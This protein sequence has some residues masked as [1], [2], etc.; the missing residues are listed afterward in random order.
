MLADE[1][2]SNLTRLL[3]NV[4]ETEA[5]LHRAILGTVEA[6]EG[7]S[8]VISVDTDITRTIA[9]FL[10]GSAKGVGIGFVPEVWIRAFIQKG[11]RI[12]RIRRRVSDIVGD[13]F[14][15]EPF[16]S[17][18]PYIEVTTKPDFVFVTGELRR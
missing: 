6:I 16:D 1:F 17:E 2:R 14:V 3:E 11:T 9:T 10:G 4:S 7:I 15:V 8:G 12:D 18:L 13:G 5:G